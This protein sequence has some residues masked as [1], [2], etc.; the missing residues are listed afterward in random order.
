MKYSIIKI[1]CIL[2]IL[3]LIAPNVSYGDAT[4]NDSC[5]MALNAS[6]MLMASNTV[7]KDTGT[8]QPAAEQSNELETAVN[9]GSLE[10]RFTENTEENSAQEASLDESYANTPVMSGGY[11]DQEWA[12]YDNRPAEQ[13]EVQSIDPYTNYKIN[14]VQAQMTPKETYK[15]GYSS[16]MEKEIHQLV[17]LK[18]PEGWLSQ[19]PSQMMAA[20]SASATATTLPASYDWRAIGNG[21]PPVRNQ[22]SCGSCWAFG[23]AGLLEAQILQKCGTSIDLSEEY[24][25]D[26]NI[27]GWS[28][29][30][31][32]WAHDY[33]MSK[34]ITGEVPG[35]VLET[36]DPYT[37]TKGVCGGPYQ[38]PYKIFNWAYITGQPIPSV[39]AIKSAIYNYGPI[40]AAIYVGPKFQ[41]YTGGIFNSN[42]SGTIN[43]AINIVGWVDD[44]GTDNG[45]WI[46]R[47]SWGASWG[48]QGYMR[49]RYGM[50]QVGYAAN[51]IEFTCPS[52]TP[53]PPVVVQKAELNGAFLSVSDSTNGKTVKASLRTYNTGDAKAGTFKIAYYL[54]TNGIAK[55]SAL[56]TAT[57]SSGLAVN[58]STGITTTVSFNKSVRGQYLMAVI[59]PDGV[60]AEKVETNNTVVVRIP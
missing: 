6:C 33:H 29:G 51:Y 58:A 60:I 1:F 25:V 27:D 34:A 42:E 3:C 24:L 7:D 56:G 44:L 53:P 16:A 4:P 26:C 11:I 13:V 36:S 20:A 32:W 22:S 12:A 37:A 18:E 50:S 5:S 8:S 9:H 21:V 30:G 31:G 47:N 41:A 45:Y 39:Q 17:G 10:V 43:H 14:A 52:S 48:E 46:L 19:A 35:G 55:S 59:D 40:A 57:I 54:S 49:I 15:V 23:T 38:H 28:C 2:A